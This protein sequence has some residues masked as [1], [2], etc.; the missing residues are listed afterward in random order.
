MTQL[1]ENKGAP[2]IAK[3]EGLFTETRRLKVRVICIYLDGEEMNVIPEEMIALDP[4]G[5]FVDRVAVGDTTS[6]Q[7]NDIGAEWYFVRAY[8]SA[9]PV[10]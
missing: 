5:E 10:P 4:I 3:L 1:K 7:G 8:D 2:R 6:G 9:Q